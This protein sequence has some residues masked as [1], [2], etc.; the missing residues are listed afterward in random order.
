MTLKCILCGRKTDKVI[1]IIDKV[2]IY[3]CELCK[4]GFVSQKEFKKQ[5][6]QHL[7]SFDEYKKV[8]KVIT[9]RLDEL[10]DIIVKHKRKGTLLEVGPG[11]GLLSHFLLQKGNYNLEVVEPVLIPRYLSKK[12]YKMHK[13]DLESFLKKRKK[14]YDLIIMFDV[15]EHL[16]NPFQSLVKLNFLLKKGGIIVI[17]TPNYKS[18][19]AEFTKKWSWWMI[20]DHKWFF[21]TI[22]LRKILTKAGFTESYTNTYEDWRDFKKNLDGN[23]TH[24]KIPFIRKLAKALFFLPFIPF[25][26]VFRHFFWKAGRGGLIFS[27]SKK[28]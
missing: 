10:T 22:S 15:I 21:T 4:L 8:E 19:M 27:I 1:Q 23:F 26:F 12:V 24:L 2:P 13:M 14:K 28:S 16:E 9:H 18:L 5:S 6:L 3:E 17:Q 11:F 20:E 7:Y 25:Y